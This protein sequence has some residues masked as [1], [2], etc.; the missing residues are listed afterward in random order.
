MAENS[1]I[2]GLPERI[3]LLRKG[4]PISRFARDAGVDEG[5][6]RQYLQAKT[7]PSLDNLVKIA[8][9][10][11]VS[12]DWLATGEGVPDISTGDTDDIPVQRLA[13]RASAGGGAV[14]VDEAAQFMRFPRV[15]LGHIGVRPENARILEARGESMAPTINDGDLLVVDVSDQTIAEGK[16]YTFSI[17]DDVFVKRLR[18]TGGRVL[19]RS[20]NRDLYPDEETVPS[21]LPFRLYGRVK[22]AG[23]N[24]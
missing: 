8:R 11:N 4:R 9:A 16:I 12:V 17:G 20:D 24:L 23:R 15:I 18:R 14:V 13:F 7:S 6:I 1:T 22:W 10:N 19:I 5:S 21:D 3:E 2:S